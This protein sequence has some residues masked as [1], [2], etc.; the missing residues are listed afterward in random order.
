MPPFRE[1]PS[2]RVVAYGG[3]PTL[4]CR[5]RGRRRRRARRC[6]G[7][8][9]RP[10][11]SLRLSGVFVEHGVAAAEEAEAAG[12][13]R[14]P[15]RAGSRHRRRPRR[16]KCRPRRP[17]QQR[18]ARTRSVWPYVAWLNCAVGLLP[19]KRGQSLGGHF[20]RVE[21]DQETGEHDRQEYDGGELSVER[22]EGDKAE[23]GG[24]QPNEQL[25]RD[26]PEGR[27]ES[28]DAGALHAHAS[29]GCR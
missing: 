9:R 2:T 14:A 25:S 10:R 12:R 11:T 16:P 26:R 20:E 23:G 15:R 18:P 6:C 22:V 17:R 4:P 21:G 27:P 1:R 28:L 13:M 24:A 5:G 3:Y 29:P 8:L 7:S 19:A